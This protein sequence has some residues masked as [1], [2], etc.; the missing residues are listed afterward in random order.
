MATSLT[1]IEALQAAPTLIAVVTAFL[2]MEG[3][4]Y[5]IA[6]WKQARAA[7]AK[8]SVSPSGRSAE[9]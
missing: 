9:A 4:K 1:Q 7:A 3:I 2:A 8:Q 6:S 5:L